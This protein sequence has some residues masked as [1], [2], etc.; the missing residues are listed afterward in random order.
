MIKNLFTPMKIGALEIPNR[1]VVPP[2]VTNYCNSDGTTT[3]R[4][5]SYYEARA[6]GGWG[7]IITEACAVDPRGRGFSFMAGLWNDSQIDSHR[8]LTKNVHKYKTKIF[9]QIF[10]AGRQTSKKVMDMDPVAPSPIPCPVKM[11]MPHELTVEEIHDIVEKFGDSAL[12][13][14]TAGYDGVEIHGSHG[15]LIAEFM[16]SFSNKR[17]DQ[18]GG[19]L[20][21]RL[22][23][24]LEIIENVRSKVGPD[25]PVGFRISADEFVTGGNTI[26]DTR[27]MAPILEN[28]GINVLHV[29]AG[30]YASTDKF[31]PPSA[32]PHGNLTHLAAEMK[33]VVNIPVI[34]VSRINDPMI[35][36]SL[37]AGG[38][39]DFVAMGRAS[40]ADP[41][42]P[43]KTAESKFAEIRM[44]IGCEQGCL[45][46]LRAD[47]PIRCL[48]NP[49]LGKEKE[50]TI[51]PA[52]EK[53]KVLVVGGGPG[54]MT[55]AIAAAE[56]GH[57]VSLFEKS[58]RLGG[59]F[60]LASIPP[61]KGEFASF[62]HWQINQM[63]KLGVEVH[64]N[65]TATLHLI[66]SKEPDEVIIATGAKPK[67]P[68][69]SGA[70]LQN[71]I[72]SF[73]VLSGKEEADQNVVVIGGGS[74]GAETA[75]Y[76]ANQGKNVTLVEVL[77]KI[78]IDYEPGPRKY[79]L[80]ELA[81][82]NV[83]V[84]VNSRVHS[85]KYNGVSVESGGI[86]KIFIPADSVVLAMGAKSD[87]ELASKLKDKSYHVSVIGDAIKIR[88]A[89][90]AIEEGYLT[91]LLVSSLKSVETL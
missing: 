68:H 7:L 77:P 5:I 8:A 2:M 36:E 24:P 12:R 76:L 6:K 32:V 10:H 52:K 3:E 25:F 40:L 91:G 48:V 56:A 54:G 74:V 71:V 47:E 86:D 38:I 50:L 51:Q 23:F 72:F 9:L 31:I 82:K 65:T 75:N 27:A 78:A 62:I 19:C 44:C 18:Y 58:D 29:S 22:R 21:N 64:L 14:K 20:S 39:A 4:Y 46:R 16:S 67:V 89:L 63:H 73:D 88:K 1:F 45:E 11:E 49:K 80:E 90:E 83:T 61:G 55:A 57:E 34:S 28:A 30:C 84:L 35:A 79:L 41:N 70:H 53:K 43:R 13:A 15:F 59:Q 26:V 81:D 85:I 87:R 42:L 17:T 33:K 37:L 60:Y 69:I 66:E